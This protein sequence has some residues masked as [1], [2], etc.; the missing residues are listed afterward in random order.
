MPGCGN[1]MRNIYPTNTPRGYPAYPTTM[2]NPMVRYPTQV[3]WVFSVYIGCWSNGDSQGQQL[4]G[5]FS[6]KLILKGLYQNCFEI[7]HDLVKTLFIFFYRTWGVIQSLPLVRLGWVRQIMWTVTR[8]KF[9]IIL[10][11]PEKFNGQTCNDQWHVESIA[12]YLGV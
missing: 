9:A 7:F 6:D 8:W 5:I 11:V 1:M 10:K 3:S 4:L 2:G 12:L